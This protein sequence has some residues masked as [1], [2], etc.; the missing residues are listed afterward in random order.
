MAAGRTLLLQAKMTPFHFREAELPSGFQMDTWHDFEQA[1]LCSRKPA[2]FSQVYSWWKEHGR[3]KAG[4]IQHGHCSY[5]HDGWITAGHLWS[6]RGWSQ[7]FYVLRGRCWI[8]LGLGNMCMC[9][10]GIQS[11]FS[12]QGSDADGDIEP[13]ASLSLIL[14]CSLVVRWGVSRQFY[15]WKPSTPAALFSEASIYNSISNCRSWRR[16][17]AAL[18]EAERVGVRRWEGAV[19]PPRASARALFPGFSS[20]PHWSLSPQSHL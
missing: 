8:S 7:N 19:V 6:D 18:D 2:F 3:W 14:L 16:E 13:T 10:S 9:T 5:L 15:G 20:S 11:Q 17:E 4:P 12:L 1:T